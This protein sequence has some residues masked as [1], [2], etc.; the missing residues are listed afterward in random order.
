MTNTPETN[1]DLYN[2]TDADGRYSLLN[3]VPVQTTK[4]NNYLIIHLVF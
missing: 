3:I 4:L 2:F 1:T